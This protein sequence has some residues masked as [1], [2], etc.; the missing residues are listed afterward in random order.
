MILRLAKR[1]FGFPADR[2]LARYGRKAKQILAVAA[3]HRVLSP[4]ALFDRAQIL[5]ERA[6]A[7]VP[8]DDLT[9]PVFALVREAARRTLG[10]EHVP[11]QLI[12]GLALQDSC[13]AE[14]KTGE[15]KTLA[16]TLVCAL[17]ALAGRGVHIATPNDYLAERDANWMRPVYQ[18]LGLNVGLITQQMDDDTRR[19][20]YACDVTYGIAS[21]FG[22][23]YLRDNMKFSG[24]ETVQRGHAFALV[25]EADAVLIDDAGMPLALF[26]PLGDQSSFYQLI[27]SIV[28]TLQPSHYEIDDR[29][30]VVLTDRGYDAVER[31]LRQATL[32]KMQVSLHDIESISL[33]HHTVQALRAHTLLSR[34]RDYIVQDSEI[35][36]IDKFTGRTMPGRR[37]DEGLHQALEAKEGCT[38]AE[39]TRTLASITFQTFFQ[40]YD[41]LAGMTGTAIGDI[42]EYREVYGLDVVAIPAHRPLIRRDETF[43]HP[44]RDEKLR[45]ILDEVES[46]RTRQQPVL[47]GASSIEHSDAL[48]A[49]LEAHGWTQNGDAAEK[50]FTVLNARHHANEARIIA[51]AGMPGAVTIATAMAGRGTDIRLGGAQGDPA[52]RDRVVAAGGLLVIGTEHHEYRRLDAQLRGRSGRQGDPGRS[53][54]HAS[55]QDDLLKNAPVAIT[56]ISDVRIDPAIAHRLVAA[57]Q[58]RIEARR[59]NSRIGL[60]RFEA[61][62]QRQRDTVYRMRREIRDDIQPLALINS[63]RNDTIDDLMERFAPALG[64]W[65]T[66][67]L[68]AMVR[69]IL[70]L[71][72]PI[73]APSGNQ[74]ADSALLRQRIG[75]TADRWMQG[76]IEALGRNIINDI[77][78][79]IMMAMLDQLW[80]EQLERLEHLKRM[81]GDRRL[82]PHKVM[83]EFQI[84]AF[85]LF[86]LMM[87]DFRYEVT[88]HAM[89]LGTTVS[90]PI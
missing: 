71:A 66:A 7:G 18:A 17:N 60:L 62:I 76:K 34:D 20:A 2:R 30:R 49:L 82:P 24:K 51:L 78:R 77:L 56:E 38:I 32:L 42:D 39:E 29:R 23:D 52:L 69:S 35:V 73:V 89:R 6:M 12:G 4:T 8:L 5:R 81:V 25:D 84:E 43:L 3:E 15:G 90:S 9:I 75:A 58:K 1:A 37:Y 46:A 11:E 79:R 63:L 83:A 26:G 67:S 50:T 33:L 68:D 10:E 53:V 59:F 61:V 22:F 85:A 87:K 72:V 27:D 36:I 16:A 48:A 54:F 41:R 64:A 40:R 86:E 31:G 44:T 70:T 65:D 80:S 19:S 28:S 55:L 47:I 21:E 88:T 45:A 14:M 74:A 13:I 57:S